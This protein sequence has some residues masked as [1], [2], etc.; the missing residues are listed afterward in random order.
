MK[1]ARFNFQSCITLDQAFASVG[2]YV[3]EFDLIS[4]KQ[5]RV[6]TFHLSASRLAR[7]FVPFECKCNFNP[8][9]KVYK[10]PLGSV[11]MSH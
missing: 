3:S 7:V 5:K 11:A 9:N 2:M 4:A 8:F 10:T 6:M 1:R